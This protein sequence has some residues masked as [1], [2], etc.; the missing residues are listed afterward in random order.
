MI[1][2]HVKLRGTQDDIRW[3][4]D[5]RKYVIDKYDTWEVVVIKMT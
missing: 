2:R 1:N 3:C 4:Q 5:T